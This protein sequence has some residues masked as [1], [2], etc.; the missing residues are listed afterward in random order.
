MRAPVDPAPRAWRRGALLVL[1]VAPLVAVDQATKW[2]AD[3]RMRLGESIPVVDGWF[4]LRYS[5]NP[6]A[7]FS[8]GAS[9]EPSVR[10]ASF[11]AVTIAAIALLLVLFHRSSSA[12]RKLRLG[13]ALLLAGAMGNLID[14]VLAGEVVDFLHLHYRDAFHWATFNVADVYICLG[15]GL[16]L[17]DTLRGSGPAGAQTDHGP[18]SEAT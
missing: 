11:V 12:Q 17:T 13:V 8:L 15:L 9:V 5:R 10:R 7:F 2:L 4:Q 14:R 18:T 3:A 6:G 16:L 1:A